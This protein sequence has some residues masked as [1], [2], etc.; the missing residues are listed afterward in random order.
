MVDDVD[1]V[2]DVEHPVPV[3]VAILGSD[4]AAVGDW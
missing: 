4:G 1:P 2:S 3:H